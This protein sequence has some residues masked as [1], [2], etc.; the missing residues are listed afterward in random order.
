MPAPRP[1]QQPLE[2]D[3]NDAARSR[4]LKPPS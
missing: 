4:A 3:L 2:L 1:A